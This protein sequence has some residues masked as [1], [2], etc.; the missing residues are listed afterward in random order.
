MTRILGIV[1]LV[2]ALYAALLLSTPPAGKTDNLIDVANLQ[3]QYGIVTLGAALVII[4]GGIDLS[5]GSVVGCAAVLFGVVM[6]SGVHP[7]AAVLLVLAFGA[8]VGLVN[9]LLVTRL[10]LQAFLVTLCGM[11]VYR[12]L[13]RL[14]GGTVSRNWVTDPRDPAAHP[15]FDQPL[16]GL[17][18]LTIGKDFNGELLFPGEFVLLLVL[19]AVLGFFL[20]RTAY[21]RY[22]YAIGHNELAAEYAGVNVNRQRVMVYVICSTLAALAG[23]LLFLNSPSVQSDA[24]GSSWELFAILGAVLGGCSLRGGE[25][26]A[27]GM[28]LGAMVMPVVDNFVNLRGMKSD[29]I[30]AVIGL[31]LLVGTIIDEV[32]RRRSKAG[33]V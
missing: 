24:G 25:G 30:P 11:F 8:T 15:E 19:A 21:G 31:T 20:H 2:T 26:T 23:V 12:G 1:G 29:G 16:R 5:I 33:K 6:K 32:I 14:I 9:G 4:V 10:K 13:A 3:G 22:W 18:F 7:Y 17:R 27:V 28:V